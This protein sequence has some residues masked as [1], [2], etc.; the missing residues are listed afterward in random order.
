MAGATSLLN[1]AG[2]GASNWYALNKTGALRRSGYYLA[3][4][5]PG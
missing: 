1:S 4:R 2:L 3:N 5:K